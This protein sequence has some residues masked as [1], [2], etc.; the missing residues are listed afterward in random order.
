[1]LKIP[2]DKLKEILI[3][4]GILESNRF[5]VAIQEGKRMGR[6]AAEILL[7]DNIITEEYYQAAL[8]KFYGIE[9]ANL[10]D[11]Q[12]DESALRLLSEE[13][14]REKGAIVFGKESDGTLLVALEDP[15]DLVTISFLESRLKTKIKTFLA[16]KDD[17]NRGLAF[18]GKRVSEDFAKTIQE[19]IE[20]SLQS[21]IS[22]KEATEAAKDLPIVALTDNLL[23][24][25]LSLRSSDIHLEVLEDEVLVRFR[26]DGILHEIMRI[27][28]EVH[29]ALSARFKLLSGLKLDEHF[30]PQDGR[31]RYRT[32]SETIDVRVSI[33]PTFYGEKVEMRLLASVDRPLSFEEMG[34]FPDVVKTLRENIAK[35]YGMVLITGP[36]G[37]GKTTTLYAVM[38][39]INKTEVNIVTI[40]DP[41]E[42]SMKYVNQTQVNEMAGITFGA[43]LRSILRQDPNVIMVGEIRDEETAEISVQA[44]LTGHLVLS[45]LH[46][47]DA[48]TAVPRLFDLKVEPF[49]VAAVLNA[50]M[51]QRLVRKICM[52][53][54]ASYKVAPEMKASIEHQLGMLKL[55]RELK[56]PSTLFKG[57]GCPACNHTGYR[58][59][60]GIHEILNITE[61][62]RQYIVTPTFTLDGLRELARKHGYITMFEDGLRKV[63]RGMT[64][65]EEVLRVIRE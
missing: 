13:T 20:A 21:K 35:T 18:Y 54:I 51:A 2:D 61:E 28:K 37:S 63:E 45:S 32:A 17:F 26:I 27:K 11:R 55:N 30:K 4:D 5:D 31:F 19:N 12:I 58:S 16:S 64:T 56:I 42:Y 47:N 60:M 1:M 10:G 22:E 23:S 49:L 25:A 9:R 6:G 8:S 3:A 24:Y 59:R 43:G 39:V 40:E 44:A 46:T 48:P 50:I 36:T 41:I 34:V 33:L 57:K 62:I 7:E 14:A 65:L 29:A 15:S 52:T 53:C 38:N